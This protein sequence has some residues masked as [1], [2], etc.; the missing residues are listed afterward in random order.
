MPLQYTFNI[1]ELKLNYP[2]LSFVVSSHLNSY[3]RNYH[4]GIYLKKSKLFMWKVLLI[5]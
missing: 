2:P 4:F 3:S 5:Y 1:Y